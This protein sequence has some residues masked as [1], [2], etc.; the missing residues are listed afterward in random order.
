V[1]KYGIGNMM[2]FEDK[3]NNEERNAVAEYITTLR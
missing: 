3:L 1:L 2:P